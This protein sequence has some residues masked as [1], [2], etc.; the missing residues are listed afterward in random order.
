MRCDVTVWDGKGTGTKILLVVE[1]TLR[2]EFEIKIDYFSTHREVPFS[3]DPMTGK[4]VE[5]PGKVVINIAIDP[6]TETAPKEVAQK[7]ST[8]LLFEA[9]YK[10]IPVGYYTNEDYRP[11]EVAINGNDLPVSRDFSA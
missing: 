2:D 11:C 7:V 3:V 4:V 8:E 1:K 10:D 5:H 6:L 9:G